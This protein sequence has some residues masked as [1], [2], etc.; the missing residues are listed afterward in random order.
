MKNSRKLTTFPTRS[1]DGLSST[2]YIFLSVD[3]AESNIVVTI[4]MNGKS[5]N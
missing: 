5:D 4:K 1:R 2:L 3:L